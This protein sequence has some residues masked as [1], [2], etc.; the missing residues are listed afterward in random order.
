MFDSDKFIKKSD[1]V[2]RKGTVIIDVSVDDVLLVD[3]VENSINIKEALST[4]TMFFVCIKAPSMISKISVR[5]LMQTGI[6]AVNS[7]ESIG[8]GQLH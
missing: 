7:L 3:A 8:R 2:M 4:T 1:I 6:K 5:A